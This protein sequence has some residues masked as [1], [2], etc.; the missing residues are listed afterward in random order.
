M[1]KNLHAKLIEIKINVSLDWYLIVEI[2]ISYDLFLKKILEGVM[3]ID[4]YI[5]GLKFR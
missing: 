1:S 4:Q 2:K 3:V 5:V